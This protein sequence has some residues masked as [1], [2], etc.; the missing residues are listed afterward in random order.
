MTI[1]EGFLEEVVLK[2]L[3]QY[4]LTLWEQWHSRKT[5]HI[6][7]RDRALWE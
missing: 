5:A 6:Q 4:D 7:H 1:G 3:E 2:L